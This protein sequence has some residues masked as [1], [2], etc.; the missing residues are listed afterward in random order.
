MDYTMEEL[1]AKLAEAEAEGDF[2]AV[3][4]IENDIAR[5]KGEPEPYNQEWF[6]DL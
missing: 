5:L 6:E 2:E 1:K 4:C 3:A